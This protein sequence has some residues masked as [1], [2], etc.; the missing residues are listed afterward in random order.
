MDFD[1]LFRL[2]LADVRKRIF[3]RMSGRYELPEDIPYS[4]ISTYINQ[5]SNI[6][7]LRELSDIQAHWN[8]V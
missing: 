1:Q 5:L 6:D 7:L 8:R 3:N 2:F 4:A